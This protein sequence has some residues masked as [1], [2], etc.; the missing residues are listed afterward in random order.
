MD[1]VWRSALEDTLS[2][3]SPNFFKISIWIP[4]FKLMAAKMTT[5]CHF[6]RVDIL[7][8]S[9]ITQ[10]LPNFIYGLFSTNYCS[11]LND[12]ICLM[13]YYFCDLLGT[14]AFLAFFFFFFF[15]GGGG[16]FVGY[17]RFLGFFS[18]IE[19]LYTCCIVSYYTFISHIFAMPIQDL[20]GALF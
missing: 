11:C 18:N 9:F 10:F 13:N 4:F 19:S 5:V 12:A 14:Y 2:Y 15:W 17:L 8:W 16:G 7:N 3:L 20:L 1:T 6:A